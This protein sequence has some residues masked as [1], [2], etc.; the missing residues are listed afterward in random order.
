MKLSK[1]GFT[2]LLNIQILSFLKKDLIKKYLKFLEL[3]LN[4]DNEKNLFKYIEN[5]WINKKGIEFINY[6]DYINKNNNYNL[7]YIFFTNNIIESFHAKIKYY[8][9]KGRT[10]SKGFILSMKNILEANELKKKRLRGM[11]IKYNLLSK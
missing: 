5:Y 2:I 11:I 3:N 4:E 1:K 6:Y 9:P 8:L 10:S 7:K